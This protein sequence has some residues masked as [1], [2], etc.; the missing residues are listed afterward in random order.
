MYMNAGYKIYDVMYIIKQEI[1]TKNTV[2]LLVTITSTELYN[3]LSL[4]CLKL[5]LSQ[6]IALENDFK[7][8]N[9]DYK[10]WKAWHLSKAV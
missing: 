3:Y 10:A 9:I 5:W 7:C 6:V 4:C 2:A 1:L 8:K